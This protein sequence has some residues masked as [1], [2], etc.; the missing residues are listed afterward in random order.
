[1][2]QDTKLKNIKKRINE[3]YFKKIHEICKNKIHITIWKK[4]VL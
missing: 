3:S 2:K 4:K 1:M